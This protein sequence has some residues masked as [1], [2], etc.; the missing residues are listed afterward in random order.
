MAEERLPLFELGVYLG[1]KLRRRQFPLRSD[2][3]KVRPKRIF[4][5]DTGFAA[6]RADSVQI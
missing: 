1:G 2:P 4:Q 5:T 6:F 3:L